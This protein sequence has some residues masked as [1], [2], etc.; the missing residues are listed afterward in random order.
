MADLDILAHHIATFGI[1]KYEDEVLAF[2]ASAY[3]RGVGPTLVGI[4]ADQTNPTVARERAF[5]RLATAV[6]SSNHSSNS[7]RLSIVA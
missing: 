3:R 4:L 2:A 6:R 1:D 5:A 7:Q